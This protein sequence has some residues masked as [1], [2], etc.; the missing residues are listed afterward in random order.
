MTLKNFASVA[1][2]VKLIAAPYCWINW[3]MS[4]YPKLHAPLNNMLTIHGCLLEKKKVSLSHSSVLYSYVDKSLCLPGSLFYSSWTSVS[5]ILIS[6]RLLGYKGNRRR[7]SSASTHGL[8]SWS[9]PA[10]AGLLAEGTCWEA[11]VWTDSWN[12]RQNDSKPK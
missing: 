2:W 4:S 1:P 3:E 9:S 7:L 8:P 11:K 5:N 6:F 12:S 10:D